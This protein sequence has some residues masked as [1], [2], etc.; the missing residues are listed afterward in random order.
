MSIAL[1]PV[2]SGLTAPTYLTSPP[3]D[4]RLFI[5]EQ[6]GRIRILENGT[7]RAAPFLDISAQVAFGG[8]R[9]LFAVA[10]HPGYDT[11]GRFFVHYTDGD[12]DTRVE[13]YR[14][15]AADA[16][17]ADPASASL[18]LTVAQ[19]FANHNG[20]SIVFGPDGMFYLALG[21]GGS[22]GDPLGNAQNPGSLLGA[23]LRLDVDAGT[24]YA[25]P[26]DNP[27]AGA[28]GARG[29]IWAYGLRNPWR[30]AFDPADGLL[31]VAD[32]GQNAWEEINVVPAV[33]GGLNYGW[34]RMEGAHCFLDPD[35]STA[36]LV[37]P[38]VEYANGSGGSCAVVG[39]AVYRGTALPAL[40]GHYFYS[41]AC[42][43]F[44]RSFR[45]TAAGPEDR[46]AWTIPD[47]GP[48]LSFG[49][50]AAGELYV[51]SAA[52]TVYRL[53]PD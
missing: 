32:V 36:G 48:V 29:E 13:E 34:N 35:C 14:R 50:D 31:Y 4:P 53:A 10:F 8:E 40:V 41:D 7:L 25:V 6:P 22:G 1:A 37:L 30:I 24:P 12:G 28:P 27:F 16:N 19:P 33:A 38:V 47:I 5:A 46:R 11:N 18:I 20:G 42:A 51:L 44:L 49:T 23:L 52:G 45:F 43:G 17:R 26:P 39:G 15:D 2:A 3:G 9:G 21:D